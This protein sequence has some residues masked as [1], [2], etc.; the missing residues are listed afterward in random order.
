MF[1]LIARELLSSYRFILISYYHVNTFT[2]LSYPNE[3]RNGQVVFS[4][5]CLRVLSSLQWV[6]AVVSLVV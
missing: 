2:R 3:K 5:T 4:L 1:S 6:R